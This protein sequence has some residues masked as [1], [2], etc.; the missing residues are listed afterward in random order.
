MYDIPDVSL[1]GYHPDIPL[2]GSVSNRVRFDFGYRLWPAL[3]F[4]AAYSIAPRVQDPMLFASDIFGTVIDP[5]SYRCDDLDSRLYPRDQVDISS[6]A[7]Y[8]NLDRAFFTLS[9][10]QADLLVGRQAVAWGSARTVNPTDVIAPYAYTELDTEN[11]VGVDAVRLR[12]PIGFMGEIDA[13]WVFGDDFRQ[14]NSAWFL[15]GRTN[16]AR[17]DISGMV[18]GFRDHLMLGADMTRAIGGAGVLGRGCLR[19]CGWS[20]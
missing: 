17:T 2:L 4:D 7:I 19:G 10:P 8:Q 12:V 3:R 14:D 5:Y 1:A 16:L 9:L 11:R 15:R 6:V 18:V 13:G 20:R